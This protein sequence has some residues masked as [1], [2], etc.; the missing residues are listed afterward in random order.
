MIAKP[1]F[2]VGSYVASLSL[3]QWQPDNEAAFYT[4]L[5]KRPLIRGLEHGFYGQLH[6]YDDDWFLKN[7]DPRWDFIFTC[8]PG[9]MERLES[10]PNFGLA[11][12][13]ESG[14]KEA[15]E[16]IRAANLAV[17]TLNQYLGRP[18][19]I[20]VLVHSAPA[21]NS[22]KEYFSQSLATI[23]DWDWQG[24]EIHVEHCD[25]LRSDGKHAKGFL[26]LE[27]EIAAIE[28]VKKVGNKTPLDLM[29]NWGRSVIE[30]RNPETVLQ[31]IRQVKEKNLLKGFIFSGTTD[32]MNSPYGY[33]GD[34]HTPAP[35]PHEGKILAAESL[36]TE[37]EIKKSLELLPDELSYL[38][39][40]VMPRPVDEDFS[41]SLVFI[42]Y[43]LRLFK[44]G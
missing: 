8:I 33:F 6:R 37:T 10:N 23:C 21:K 5:K 7:I 41:R 27:N 12:S 4:E 19:V 32:Q 9:T 18:A 26:T 34:K 17:K 29:L 24:A 25:A 35:T 36:M 14:R 20:A 16:F 22:S 11:S 38:G 39:L 3:R 15:L 1:S 31:H 2:I 40:K 28:M 43:L 13:D 30:G 44:R 42:D